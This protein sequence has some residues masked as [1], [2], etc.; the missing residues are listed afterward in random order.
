MGTK[1]IKFYL[2]IPCVIIVLWF[3]YALFHPNVRF[4]NNPDQISDLTWMYYSG[5]QILTNPFNLYNSNSILVNTYY[6]PA[7]SLFA[8]FFLSPFPLIFAHYLMAG[9]NIILGIFFVLELNKIYKILGLQESWKRFILLI[10]S[11]CSWMVYAQF[12]G[13][14]SKMMVAFIFTISIRKQLQSNIL[15]SRKGYL[16]YFLMI[17]ALSIT[18]YFIFL[19]LILLFDD[20]KIKDIM[21]K[22]NIKKIIILGIFFSIQNFFYFIYPNLIFDGFIKRGLL[23]GID[24]GINT[25]WLIDSVYEFSNIYLSWFLLIS[26]FVC[27]IVIKIVKLKFEVKIALFG[28]IYIWFGG[29]GW[30]EEFIPFSFILFIFI[31]YLKEVKSLKDLLFK[32]KLVSLCLIIVFIVNMLPINVEMY[33]KYIPFLINQPFLTLL[34]FR[35]II[36]LGFLTIFMFFLLKKSRFLFIVYKLKCKECR[37]EPEFLSEPEDQGAYEIYC[38]NCNA[39]LDEEGDF[40]E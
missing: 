6:M 9:L 10:I 33:Y 26:L 34:I 28:L 17:F 11:V 25:F 15:S 22:A 16:Y 37:K 5:K 30:S 12:Y 13:P 20:I 4:Y 27:S 14:Q 36:L 38:N 24:R 23:Y 32:H 19:F 8:A 2:L 3:I 1:K 7:F 18:P 21:K 39:Y 40:I 29:F 31:P 35:Y